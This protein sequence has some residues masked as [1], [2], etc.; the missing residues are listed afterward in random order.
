MGDNRV[1]TST[2]KSYISV[3]LSTSQKAYFFGL[4]EDL[5]IHENDFVVIETERGT[6]LGQSTIEP[7]PIEKYTGSLG[8][9]PVLRKAT[10]E[11]LKQH[12]S[13]ARDAQ[14]AMQICEKEIKNLKL[15][16]HL[17]SAEYTLDR[18]KITFTY[19][20]DERV[21][22]RDLLKVL[23]H[24][25][26]TRIELRQIG[27]RDKA[28]TIGGIGI[29]GLPICCATFLNKF[30]S[31]GIARAKNQMLAINVPKISGH[32]EKLICCLAYEDDYYTEAKK[33]YPELG[34]KV[35]MD[36]KEYIVTGI[37]IISTIVKIE[38]PED[39]IQFLTLEDLRKNAKF[40]PA[41][42]AKNRN[43]AN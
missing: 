6:V 24:Q 34:S 31:V 2:F 19:S 16:M 5:D 1:D 26:R 23:A 32:C 28:K 20:A 12:E 17:I 39:D 10:P 25:L 42:F 21:D 38:G 36:K 40:R 3:K 14:F 30:D 27:S 15:E 18:S 8:L 4:K 33:D 43:E 7:I 9:K 11:D 13:N 22:F 35:W 37:N 29:C 41:R